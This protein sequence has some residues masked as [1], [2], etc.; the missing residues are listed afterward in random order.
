MSYY[1]PDDLVRRISN[2]GIVRAQYIYTL[3]EANEKFDAVIREA[4]W[5]IR[6]RVES[7]SLSDAVYYVISGGGRSPFSSSHIGDGVFVIIIDERAFYLFLTL[8]LRVQ[9]LPP[10]AQELGTTSIYEAKDYSTKTLLDITKDIVFHTNDASPLCSQQQTRAVFQA[11]LYYIISHEI[12]HIA[13]GHLDFKSSEHYSKFTSNDEE[14]SLTLRALE[15]DADSSAT[16]AVFSIFESILSQIVL[17]KDTNGSSA[18]N[19]TKYFRYQYM[20]G[21]FLSHVYLDTLATDYV[22][23][24]HPIGYARFLTTAV[25]FEQVFE[26]SFGRKAARIPE[27]VRQLLVQTFVKLSGELS[28]LRHPI[29]TNVIRHGDGQDE[30]VYEYN[31]IGVLAGI[32]H[33]EPLHGRWAAIRP[34]LEPLLRGGILAPAYNGPPDSDPSPKR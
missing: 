25:I 8:C 5:I 12:A 26:N 18:R 34:Y 24:F 6:T 29:A 13:H 19:F 10:L 16:T 20:L 28:N 32:S 17:N 7:L 23:K 1:A 33:L 31:G 30:L 2:L 15:M 11:G 3:D 14:L 22:P 27:K 21:S 4:E 9:S